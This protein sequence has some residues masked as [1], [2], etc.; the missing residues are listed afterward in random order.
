VFFSSFESNVDRQFADLRGRFY[1]LE[2][3]KK[4]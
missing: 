3:S 2:L 1:Y 4:F